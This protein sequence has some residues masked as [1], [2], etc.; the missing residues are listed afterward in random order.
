M[1]MLFCKDTESSHTTFR[2]SGWAPFAQISIYLLE[3]VT[4][5]NWS[6]SKNM[7]CQHP[8][9]F[10]GVQPSWG[11]SSSSWAQRTKPS[12]HPATPQGP[13]LLGRP[14][15]KSAHG[16]SEERGFPAVSSWVAFRLGSQRGCPQSPSAFRF[17]ELDSWPCLGGWMG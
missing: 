1:V 2:A 9:P 13:G 14:H 8:R 4:F 17:W 5:Y 11:K 6:S 16:P 7:E 10:K 3:A 15:W 12:P